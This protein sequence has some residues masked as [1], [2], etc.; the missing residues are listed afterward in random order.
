VIHEISG[1]GVHAQELQS[2]LCG[3][4]YSNYIVPGIDEAFIS[5]NVNFLVTLG[6]GKVH[7]MEVL[8]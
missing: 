3:A 2:A 8:Q 4:E 5:S 6:A 7:R 1:L